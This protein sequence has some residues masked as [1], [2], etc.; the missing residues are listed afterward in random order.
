MTADRATWRCWRH[1][2]K[3]IVPPRPAP[4]RWVDVASS[5]C[6]IVMVPV[7]TNPAVQRRIGASRC[8]ISSNVRQCHAVPAS[9]AVG[10]RPHAVVI[11]PTAV[12]HDD[13]L[14][15]ADDPRP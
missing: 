7:T 4:T 11:G 1:V 15:A 10:K 6:M 8:S 2:R 13:E 12:Q 14:A 3:A 5:A 9:K